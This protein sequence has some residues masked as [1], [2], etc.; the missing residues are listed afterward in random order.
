M[1]KAPNHIK[2]LIVEDNSEFSKSI[3]LLLSRYCQKLDLVSDVDIAKN[4]IQ[5]IN[6]CKNNIYDIIFTDVQMPKMDGIEMIRKIKKLTKNQVIVIISAY[7]FSDLVQESYDLK[8]SYYLRKPF[9]RDSLFN[10]IKNYQIDNI[11]N[12]CELSK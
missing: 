9:D 5:A 8:V 1:E 12:F 7:D 2:M 4:G 6:F 11:D 3:E 10:I